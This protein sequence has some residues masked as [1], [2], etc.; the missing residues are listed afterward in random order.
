MHQNSFFII[1]DLFDDVDR[2]E[3]ELLQ[4]FEICAKENATYNVKLA[5]D[6]DKERTLSQ[7]NYI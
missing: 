3:K 5:I 4:N 2:F 1:A 6:F 7:P